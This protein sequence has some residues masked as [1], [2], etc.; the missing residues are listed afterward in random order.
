MECLTLHLVF[1]VSDVP[2]VVFLPEAELASPCGGGQ[3]TI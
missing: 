3:C 2:D 1:E